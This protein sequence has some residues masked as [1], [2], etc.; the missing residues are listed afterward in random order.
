[1]LKT[2]I[3]V[4]L[5][6]FN[7]L[8]FSHRCFAVNF[9]YL[10]NQKI[11]YNFLSPI[12]VGQNLKHGSHKG[13]AAATWLLLSNSLSSPAQHGWHSLHPSEMISAKKNWIDKTTWKTVSLSQQKLIFENYWVSERTPIFCQSCQSYLVQIMTKLRCTDCK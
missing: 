4:P 12:H 6:D 1:M 13:K 8:F 11:S 9:K 7:I 2:E 10:S 3:G 5:S